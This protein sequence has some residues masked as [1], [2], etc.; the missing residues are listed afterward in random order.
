MW[1]ATPVRDTS[2]A[3]GPGPTVALEQSVDSEIYTSRWLR[4]TD[5]GFGAT[6]QGPRQR[7][8]TETRSF[9]GRPH[10]RGIRRLRKAEYHLQ[11]RGGLV[12]IV[13]VEHVAVGQE[14]ILNHGL[15]IHSESSCV[16]QAHLAHF[17]G[18]IWP[19]PKLLILQ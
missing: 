19:T 9:N 5:A 12:D 8:H 1:A 16:W 3:F 14:I 18:L 10:E 15:A 6:R 7:L 11:I 17:G 13:R 4:T 2:W